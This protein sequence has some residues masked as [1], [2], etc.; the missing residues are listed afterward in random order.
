MHSFSSTAIM[1]FGSMAKALGLSAACL[2]ALASLHSC[3]LGS[4]DNDVVAKDEIAAD[5]GCQNWGQFSDG[6]D[7]EDF[8]WDPPEHYC[9]G[10][11]ST[12]LKVVCAPDYSVCCLYPNYCTP[13]GWPECPHCNAPD[14]EGR[15]VLVHCAS[16]EAEREIE[17]RSFPPECRTA[18]VPVYAKDDDRC[19]NIIYD[20]PICLDDWE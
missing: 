9:S 18:P 8:C 13:C 17:W 19:P 15:R 11:A 16:E 2:I 4:D 5:T 12:A 1:L 20:E 10:G 6:K 14:G 3:E 7:G